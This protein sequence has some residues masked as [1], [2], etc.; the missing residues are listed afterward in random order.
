MKIIAIQFLNTSIA[1][2][3]CHDCEKKNAKKKKHLK[4]W[5]FQQ[6]AKKTKK[7]PIF[8]KNVKNNF[9]LSFLQK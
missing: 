1:K 3:G 9:N 6:N 8:Q 4:L 7:H 2:S 5:D